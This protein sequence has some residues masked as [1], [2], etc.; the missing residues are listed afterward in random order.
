MASPTKTIIIP[1]FDGT[2][3][4]NILRTSVWK[5]LRSVPGLRIVII[6]PKG[7]DE[8]YIKEFGGDGVFFESSTLW[9]EGAWGTFFQGMFLHSIPTNFM[10][11]RQVDWFWHTGKYVNYFGASI[12]RFLGK[13][14]LWR[15]LLMFLGAFEPIAPEV[16]DMYARWKPD[17]VFAPTTIP[18][19]E[20][21]LMRLAR[22]DG[23]KIVGMM[24]SWDNLTSKAFP[25]IFSDYLI[26]PNEIS[27]E[28]A[29][30]FYDFPKERIVV[31]GIP[32]YDDY[33]HPDFLEPREEFFKN[34]GLDPNKKTILYTPAG[35]WMNPNDKDILASLLDAI[36]EGRIKNIQVLLRLHPAYESKAEELHGDPSMVVERPGKHFGGL[37]TYEFFDAD[38]RHLASS[39]AYSDIVIHTASTMAIEGAIYD[40]PVISLAYDGKYKL[41][42]WH[43]TRRYYD[44]EHCV[45]IIRSLGTALVKSEEEFLSAVETYF[46]YPETHKEGRKKI[47]DWECYK[48]D[49][50]ATER[51]ADVL[52]R[53]LWVLS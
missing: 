23:K 19:L 11:I 12:L 2:I 43:S 3:T 42:Y 44:R 22:K 5:R 41:D 13:F 53:A 45:P 21:S 18:S 38:V 24:K 40:K 37:K 36:K 29:T 25:R 31:T 6:P 35:D 46:T 20:V 26:V 10:R 27:I 15:N 52:F 49:G 48:M 50:K 8:L 7:K 39:I 16:R 14:S 30:K 34:L 33:I 9:Q 4:K 47:V 51:I 28:E 1:I 17:V 32:Q